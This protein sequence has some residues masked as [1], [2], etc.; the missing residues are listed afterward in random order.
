MYV[1][2]AVHIDKVAVGSSHKL[3]VRG[4]WGTSTDDKVYKTVSRT[5]DYNT[6]DFTSL[7]PEDSISARRTDANNINFD[8]KLNSSYTT[9][10][11]N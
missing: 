4:Y 9:Y 6:S 11:N 7:F 2:I 10:K 5:L 3:E 1:G 8:G